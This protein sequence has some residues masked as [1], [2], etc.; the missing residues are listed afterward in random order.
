MSTQ[1]IYAL[2]DTWNAG[3]TTFTAIKMDVLDTASAAG[4]LL[5][6]LQVGGSSRFNV[7]KSGGIVA[8]LPAAGNALDIT[9]SNA[10]N[11]GVA[12]QTRHNSASP[13]VDDYVGYW[14][15]RG[16]DSLGNNTLYGWFQ[17][18]IVDPTDGSEKGQMYIGA[19]GG[20][21][22]NIGQGVYT[23]GAAAP[24]DV[25]VIAARQIKTQARTVAQLPAAGT[26]GAGT[27]GWVSDS[28][29]AFSTAVIT[30]IVAGGG[31]NGCPVYSDGT[32]WRIG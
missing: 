20:S 9:N 27:R 16:N 30:D 1:N 14:N 5:M 13:A 22:L 3:G 6:D 17:C 7:N 4:S 29:V 2:T 8:V 12:I 28:T 11:L 25:N 32:N 26:V 18:L 21:Q 24:G 31:A 10:G 19:G 15:I 23:T